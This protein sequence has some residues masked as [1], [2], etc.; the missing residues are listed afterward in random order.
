MSEPLD[1][2][3]EE[4]VTAGV[5]RATVVDKLVSPW[6]VQTCRPATHVLRIQ[7]DIAF[8]LLQGDLAERRQVLGDSAFQYAMLE[9]IGARIEALA[10]MFRHGTR[11]P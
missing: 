8:D 3:Y 6:I 11:S 4:Q 1:E 7:A 5:Y 2:D 10:R 9:E